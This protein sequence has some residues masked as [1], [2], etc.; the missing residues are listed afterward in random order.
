[1]KTNSTPPALIHVIAHTH[2]DREW[3]LPFQEFRVRLVRVV[4][5]ILE[6][7]QNDPAYT[8]FN[9]DGQTIVLKDYLEIRPEQRALLKELVTEGR[10]GVGPWFVLPD[11]F[12]VSGEALI[13]N[14]LL[15]QRIAAEYGHV[16]KAGYIP[17]TF[18]HISQLPQILNGFGIHNAMHFRGLDEGQLTA[19][20]WWQSPDGS[21]VLL[22]H[23]PNA[24]GYAEG[25]ALPADIETAA[26]DFQAF[27]RY[28]LERSGVGSALV[29]C[30][31]D[32]LRPVRNLPAI[33]AAAERHAAGKYI[34]RQSSLEAFFAHLAQV[35]VSADLPVVQGELRQTNLTPGH[36]MR[37]L[38]H[39]LS[40]R[41]Y[42]K[43]R[44]ERI[45]TLLERWA[46]PWSV[47]ASLKSAEYPAAFLWRAWEYLLENH[48]HDSIGGCSGDATHEQM[49]T[50]FAWAAEIGDLLTRERFTLLARQIDLSQ[51]QQDEVA[52]VVFNSLPWAWQG[53]VKAS[54]ELTQFN[55]NRM[56]VRRL[57]PPVPPEE[58]NPD[59][60]AT[61]IFRW[62]THYDWAENPPLM[63][64]TAVRGLSLRALDSEEGIAVQ[65]EGME[66][67]NI[68][69]PLVTG[70][71]AF[72]DVL[73]IQAAFQTSLP[74]MGYRV[75]AARPEM[76]P[77]RLEI[78]S[79]ARNVLENA[80]LRV[81]IAANGTW[82]LTDR[83]TGQVFHHLGYFED[84]GD[85]GDGY[86]YSNPACDRLYTTLGA[87]PR[88]SQLS[89]GPVEQC[90]RIDYDLA[91]PEGLDDQRRAR[92]EA[93]IV[94][95]LRVTLRLGQ[96]S[97]RLE[98][99]IDF[100][101]RVR[102]HRLRVVF[103]SDVPADF[104]HSEAQFDVV[105]HP[106]HIVAVPP[107]AWVEDAPLTQPQ[108]SWVDVSHGRRGLTVINQGLPEYEVLDTPRREVA[109]TL[110]RAVAF[111]GAGIE[112]QTT[113]IG[114]GPHI[115]T[116]GGQIQRQLSY[117]L[118]LHPH[119]G[120]WDEDEVWRQAQ[121]N[122]IA[123][124]GFTYE[125]AGPFQGLDAPTQTGGA[126]PPVQ[127][128]LH[129]EGKNCILTTLK[130]AEQSEDWILR[131]HNPS[132]HTS[133]ARICLPFEAVAVHLAGLDEQPDQSEPI[134]GGQSQFEV[135]LP[136]H[137][138]IT[139]RIGH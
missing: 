49:E 53:V 51:L 14:L 58:L 25:S 112:M 89:P 44:N 4:D 85:C 75:Y 3:Y 33:L 72:R 42:L 56:A 23:L 45:Q 57:T 99:E 83:Q 30:G 5:E 120:S 105:T 77:N 9:L 129:V 103:P 59:R 100:D 40:S 39:I 110:L 96:A 132:G 60:L 91:L 43:Q 133:R 80:Y 52:L 63:P 93:L 12:L 107:A 15:G 50:R 22:Y 48:P 111:V 68:T 20:L 95:P 90:Y 79:L 17:D 69:R 101:N 73:R 94:C 24:M 46:E 135:E 47:L 65:I 125:V 117:H 28:E 61:E 78:C 74:P 109:I 134:T 88:I 102:D 31:V 97:R 64:D 130:Q 21:R 26:G 108:Q 138:I 131:L 106:V 82:T 55:L 11:E 84:G 86:N 137:K 76:L 32:H 8:H 6:I 38:P 13:R 10:L 136:P 35:S 37:V 118:A 116:P 7:L 104:S 18:G 124:R 34:F 139:L 113:V 41:I 123:P 121:E 54:I 19:E 98:I 62:R 115:A 81:E 27:A 119:A 36:G 70:P 87:A 126:L 71:G 16:Q 67:A 2:W 66:A 29:L 1:M 122:N 128:F 114:A 92:R 127:S